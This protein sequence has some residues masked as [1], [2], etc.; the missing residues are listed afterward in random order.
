MLNIKGSISQSS[1]GLYEVVIALTGRCNLKCKYCYSNSDNKN[2]LQLDKSTIIKL[3]DELEELGVQ[4]IAFSGGEPLLHKDFF[5]IAKF[6]AKKFNIVF[7]STNGYFI[8]NA[9]AK[10]IAESGIKNVQV[11][12][13]GKKSTH[14]QLRGNKNSFKNAVDAV[15]YLRNHNVDVT[16]T[17]TF[18]K[19]NFKEILYLWNLAKRLNCDLAVKRPIITGRATIQSNINAQTYKKLY[20]FA[21]V[22]NKK[23]MHS[24][25][26][27]HCDPL[28]IL[29]LDKKNIDLTRLNGCIAGFGLIYIRY[30]GDVYPCSKLPLKIG[31]IYTHSLK[32][33]LHSKKIME[34][35]DRNNLTGKCGKCALKYTCGGCRAS[36]LSQ[37][38]NVYS[39]DPLCWH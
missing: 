4:I 32:K 36:A 16:I 19:N 18:Q 3:F 21:I 27:M 28:R 33:I 5:E 11:S 1:S 34:L 23:N 14:N 24:K 15:K 30:N 12:I 25:I 20:N 22:Q 13:D 6:A 39:E 10:R 26:F 31:N 29:Y 17:P 7:L 8:T 35:I 2:A 9:I 37:F 38:G